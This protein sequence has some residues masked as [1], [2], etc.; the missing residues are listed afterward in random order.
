MCNRVIEQNKK[1]YYC[2]K[3]P[4]YHEGGRSHDVSY[5]Y[6]MELSRNW[7]WM[8]STFYF[9]KKHYGY[10]FSLLSVVSKLLSSVLKIIFYTLIFNR[11]KKQIYLQRFSGL[12][13]SIFSYKMVLVSSIVLNHTRSIK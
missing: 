6:Q 10:L 8:W 3:I 11:K 7:H 4:V 12:I 9:N 2:P 13:N 1:I 5:N